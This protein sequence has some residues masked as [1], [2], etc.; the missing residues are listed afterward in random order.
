[1]GRKHFM[2]SSQKFVIKDVL[3]IIVLLVVFIRIKF[4]SFSSFWVS[5][6]EKCPL[7]F[8]YHH[9]LPNVTLC[10]LRVYWICCLYCVLI[11]CTRYSNLSYN[12]TPFLGNFKAEIGIECFC[13]LATFEG[14]C[15]S[16]CRLDRNGQN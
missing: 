1:M 14:H 5:T 7:G 10:M 6:L 15:V 9:Y 11:D 2:L 12:F 4:N 8:R 3:F 13:F 16:G